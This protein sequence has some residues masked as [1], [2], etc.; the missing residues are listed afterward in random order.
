MFHEKVKLEKQAAKF[1]D[2]AN[3]LMNRMILRSGQSDFRIAE[4]EFYY[5]DSKLHPDPYVHRNERQK[6]DGAFYF[7]GS[8]IDIT[9]GAGEEG[10][11]YGGAL[12]R[13]LID[14]ESEEVITGPLRVF[15][16]LLNRGSTLELR[17]QLVFGKSMKRQGFV[18]SVRVMNLKKDDGSLGHESPEK[19]YF[20]KRYRFILE[21]ENLLKTLLE[22]PPSPSTHFLSCFIDPKEFP[23]LK[24]L[25]EEKT[26]FLEQSKFLEVKDK[27]GRRLFIERYRKDIDLSNSL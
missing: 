7:H 4:L 14:L 5:H 21:E 26:K 15:D 1:E 6:L 10:E 25:L 2:L 17:L 12:I 11:V 24:T 16:R 9:F 8:G 20:L 18:Q 19:V 23:S 27:E 22:S 13:S 3:E